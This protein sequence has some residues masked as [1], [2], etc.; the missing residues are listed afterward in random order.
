MAV[1]LY[2]GVD[3]DF[4]MVLNFCWTRRYHLDILPLRSKKYWKHLLWMICTIN[5][6]GFGGSKFPSF[7]PWRV[8]HQERGARQ[9]DVKRSG[10]W[11]SVDL[12]KIPEDS[13]CNILGT[14]VADSFLALG[15]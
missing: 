14:L 1:A 13:D 15:V 4:F 3:L 8:V 6:G 5:Q 11:W 2:L 12:F 9:P 7:C 10:K